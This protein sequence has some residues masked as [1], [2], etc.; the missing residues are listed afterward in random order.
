MAANKRALTSCTHGSKF[1][2]FSFYFETDMRNHVGIGINLCM[3]R[4]LTTILC[5]GAKIYCE[6]Y[7]RK[8]ARSQFCLI[9]WHFCQDCCRHMKEEQQKGI[10]QRAIEQFA[11]VTVVCLITWLMVTLGTGGEVDA[12]SQAARSMTRLKGEV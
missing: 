6:D 7:S 8:Y 2:C 11:D 12:P 10:R 9:S 1:I 5:E 3:S 4:V